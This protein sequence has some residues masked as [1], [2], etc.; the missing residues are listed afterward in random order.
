MDPGVRLRE[1]RAYAELEGRQR[2]VLA[3]RALPVVLAADDEPAPPLVHPLAE[4]RVA[5]TEGELGDRRD[6][7]A[8]GH[9]LDA[10]G[11]HVARRDVVGNDDQDA[12][13]DCL[14]QGRNRR[15]RHDVAAL[16]ERDRQRL[17]GRRRQHDLP[18][19]HRCVRRRGGQ[20]RRITEATGVRDHPGERGCAR[21][22][23]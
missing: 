21:R 23:R 12:T 13:R 22:C 20:R 19:V 17:F 1:H 5:M 9:H 15:R 2:G 14:G 6:V 18:V 11:R 16:L 3:R 4:L 8:V 7:R 10:V